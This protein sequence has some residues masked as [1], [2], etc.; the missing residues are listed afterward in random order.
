MHG[1]IWKV[2]VKEIDTVKRGDSVLILGSD[3]DGE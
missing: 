2:F 3:E 1:T